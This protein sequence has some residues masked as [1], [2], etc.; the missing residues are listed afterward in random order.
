[1]LLLS[2][3]EGGIVNSATEHRA[4][5]RATTLTSESTA[6]EAT[7]ALLAAGATAA[8]VL[9]GVEPIGVITLQDLAGAPGH[10]AAPDALA[11]DVMGHECVRIDPGACCEE[12][13]RRYQQA[14]WES[15][16]R[17]HP[18]AVDIEDRRRRAFR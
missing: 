10:V 18:A 15:L 6:A 5:A 17:R 8:V 1:M 4:T 16:Y 2:D 13:L 14:A 7:L 12:T 9:E 11:I 3:N